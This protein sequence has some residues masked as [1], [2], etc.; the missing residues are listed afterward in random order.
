MDT[1]N[2][3]FSDR[4]LDFRNF[5]AIVKSSKATLYFLSRE[6]LESFL[7][8]MPNALVMDE[9]QTRMTFLSRQVNTLLKVAQSEHNENQKIQLIKKFIHQ[10]QYSQETLPPTRRE[11]LTQEVKSRVKREIDGIKA[12]QDSL[13]GGALNESLDSILIETQGGVDPVAGK[14][15]NRGCHDPHVETIQI[16]VCEENAE[17]KMA[18]VQK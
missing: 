12:S 15:R 3:L 10:T 17:R 6:H 1:T 16:K 8:F 11:E 18:R 5:S 13:L 4:S 9:V 2:E 14:L 7:L